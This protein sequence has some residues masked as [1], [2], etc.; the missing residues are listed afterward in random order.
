MPASIGIG[1]GRRPQMLEQR[2]L[3]VPL[4]DERGVIL[5]LDALAQR[6][7][8]M[9]ELAHH[10]FLGGR[11]VGF[12]GAQELQ[13]APEQAQLLVHDVMWSVLVGHGIEQASGSLPSRYRGA[14][15]LTGM[16]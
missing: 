5:G 13:H 11:G 10:R 15:G 12:G 3:P 6:F 16:L 4:L 2:R 14:L 8:Q 1:S 9:L 7:A